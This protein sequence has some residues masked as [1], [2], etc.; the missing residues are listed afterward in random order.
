MKNKKVQKY[1]SW[2]LQIILGLLFLAA[3]A[4]K[5]LAAEVWIE[6]FSNWGYPDNFYLFIGVV[7]VLAAILLFIPK[8]TKQAA[9]FLLVV[10]LGA[11]LTH[12]F[13]QE[14]A[15]LIRPIIFMLLLSTLIYLKIK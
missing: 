4:G 2:A 7:E 9:M 8:F 12:I 3:G 6:K 5:F 13:N 10:M 11:V 14:A 15:E 1:I